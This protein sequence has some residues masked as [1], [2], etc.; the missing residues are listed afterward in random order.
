MRSRGSS[1]R[2]A[3]RGRAPVA[4]IRDALSRDDRAVVHAASQAL[5][6]A[7]VCRLSRAE[8]SRARARRS[9]RPIETASCTV[10]TS[11]RTRD[12]PARHQRVD[13]HRGSPRRSSRSRR[14]SARSS[15]S[16]VHHL[17]YELYKL[18]ETFHTE[19]FY[20]RESTLPMRCWR[21]RARRPAE[22]SRASRRSPLWGTITVLPEERCNRTAP[23]LLP[24]SGY[25]PLQPRSLIRA[26]ARGD[27][28]ASR[29][30]PRGHQR[31]S[32]R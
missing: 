12:E 32:D 15:T 2:R 3:S 21:K 6:D 1:L 19:G 31:W 8:D 22:L 7:L 10:F 20:K 26:R 14:F 11:P 9:V 29:P 16:S 24:G 5:I 4:R 18:P 30:P 23:P 25:R 13:A 28:S 17:D 27:E